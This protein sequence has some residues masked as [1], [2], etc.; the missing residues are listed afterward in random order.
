LLKNGCWNHASGLINWQ[1]LRGDFLEHLEAAPP[2]DLIFY[3]PFSSK[4]DT[5]LWQ[6]EVFARIHRQ[7]QPKPA[8]LYTYSASTAVRVALLLAGFFVA[9]GVG[10]GPKATTTVAFSRLDASATPAGPRLLGAEWLARWRHSGS[11]YPPGLVEAQ[12]V[13]VARCI[14]GHPQFAAR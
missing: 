4:T 6:A 3:D 11:K 10:T 8:E 2:P 5:A 13:E 14:E 1:L 12:K 7:C 9:E